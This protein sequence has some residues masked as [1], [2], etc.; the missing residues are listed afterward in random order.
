MSTTTEQQR[1][2]DA[3]PIGANGNGQHAPVA[4]TEAPAP[5]QPTPTGEPATRSRKR[6]VLL[7]VLLLAAVSG[8]FVGA[9]KFF[10]ALHHE[11]TDDATVNSHVTYLSARIAGETQEVLVDDNQYVEAGTPLVRIDA[12][13]YRIAV[14]QKRA[15]LDKAKQQVDQD[16]A[17]LEVAKAE[18]AQDVQRARQDLRQEV[19]N[20]A[21]EVAER[22][23]RKSLRDEDHRRIV[24]DA[25]SRLGQN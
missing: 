16:V 23:I 13:P 1:P 24:N 18:L 14:E 9:P 21:I 19:S 4:A 25:I 8:V 6:L 2:Q 10:Y 5:E 22:L 11:S 7:G 3:P 12:A 17:T 20:L 15:S